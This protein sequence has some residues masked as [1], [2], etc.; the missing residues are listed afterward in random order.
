MNRTML[1]IV[2]VILLFPLGVK[3]A[4]SDQVATSWGGD[5]EMAYDT[6][7]MHMLMKNPGGGVRLFDMDLLENDSP[8][9]GMS[10]KGVSLDAVWGK[11]MA[12]KLLYLDDTRAEKAYFVFFFTHQ[13]KHPLLFS[14][15]G[16]GA[17]VEN[18]DPATCHL[19]YRWIE[20]PVEWL[21]K[22][23]N[24]I[25][26]SCPDAESKSEGWNLYLARADE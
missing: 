15:N 18:W 16:H 10:E 26:L 13:G 3:S 6:G 20:F 25:D 19:T 2:F 21:K 14:V 1:A 22:G 7:F 5:A 8:G 9:A 12:R 24:V 4:W 11:N 17:R 23:G